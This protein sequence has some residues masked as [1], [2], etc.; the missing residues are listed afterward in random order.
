MSRVRNVKDLLSPYIDSEGTVI[1]RPPEAS[2]RSAFIGAVMRTLPGTIIGLNPARVSLAS[3]ATSAPTPSDQQDAVAPQGDLDVAVTRYARTEQA[4]LRRS[5]VANRSVAPCAL[6]GQEMPVELLVAAHIKK[7]SLCE[8]EEKRDLLNI[9][10]LACKLGCDD[11]Y[12]L[13]YISVGPDGTIITVT[14]DDAVHGPLVAKR[15]ASLAGAPCLAFT[16]ANAHYFEWH[17]TNTYPR[18]TQ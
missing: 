3:H 2:Y 9:G 15:I 13:G 4:P 16:A 18:T 5:L 8:D 14:P 12:E 1:C 6:C 11:F 17:R 7:R 10:M